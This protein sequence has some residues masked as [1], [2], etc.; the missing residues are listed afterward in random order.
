VNAI[1][2]V[3]RYVTQF[4]LFSNCYVSL[5]AQ[6]GLVDHERSTN[7]SKLNATHDDGMVLFFALAKS[8][9]PNCVKL[10]RNMDLENV[11]L[12]FMLVVD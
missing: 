1:D 6:M 5:G 2:L 11:Y 3:Q 4:T 7:C 8:L 10:Q 12:L 9:L